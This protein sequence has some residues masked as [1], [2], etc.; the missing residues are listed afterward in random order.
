MRV[1]AYG[2]RVRLLRRRDGDTWQTHARERDTKFAP[3]AG[4]CGLRVRAGSRLG[5]GPSR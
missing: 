1:D 3:Q 4:A 2:E 5:E